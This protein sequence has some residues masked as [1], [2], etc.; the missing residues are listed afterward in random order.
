MPGPAPS[1]RCGRSDVL[2]ALAAGPGDHGAWRR[3]RHLQDLVDAPPV[4]G[5]AVVMGASPAASTLRQPAA[6]RAHAL[7]EPD[8][9]R[10][11]VAPVPVS[12]LTAKF[13]ARHRLHYRVRRW[14]R[15][16]VPAGGGPGLF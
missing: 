16:D 2:H 11:C 5:L 3:A 1:G 13:P 10:A 8:G 6:V 9:D 7:D 4:T 14:L 15:L 12:P